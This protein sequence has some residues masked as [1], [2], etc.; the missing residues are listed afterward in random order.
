MS[1]SKW[2]QILRNVKVLSNHDF[3]WLAH[4]CTFGKKLHG[5]LYL[6]F[7]WLKIL[8]PSTNVYW[9]SW[10]EIK[11]TVFD[12]SV[13][14]TVSKYSRFHEEKLPWQPQM[15]SQ[16]LY[17]QSN[18]DFKIY[19]FNTM[20]LS[21]YKLVPLD[22]GYSWHSDIMFDQQKLKKTSMSLSWTASHTQ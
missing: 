22:H 16:P 15:H 7:K 20:V 19:L 13:I 21:K 1:F 14:L 6:S 12:N 4:Q 5:L 3:A 18:K 9:Y 17:I 10:I 11:R 8:L 2:I